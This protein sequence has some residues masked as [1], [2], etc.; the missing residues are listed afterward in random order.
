MSSP[1]F[2]HEGVIALVR[3]E[4]S[5]AASLL[6]DLFRIEVPHFDEARLREAELNQLVPVEYS[7]DAVVLFDVIYDK[8]KPVF[9]TIFEVQLERK[10]RKLY[11]WP[12]YAVAARARYECP[13][14][15][16]AVTPDPAVAQWASQPIDLGDGMTYRVRVIGPDGVPPVT[17]HDRAR[18]EPRLAVLSAV[19]HGHGEVDVAV[20]VARTAIHAVSSLP[21]EQR[22]LYS[23]LIE[24]A[25]SRAARKALVMDPQIEKFF[26]EEHRRSRDQAK[27]EGKAEGEAKALMMI[28][29]HRGMTITDEQQRQIIACSDA[30]TVERW[31]DR[32]LFVASVDELLS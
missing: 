14:V 27:A 18:R 32:A 8:S 7:A 30:A 25:L 10:D 3:D 15:V 22:L 24:K 31:L 23:L 6:R 17:D 4:P 28:L 1:S 21:E 9:G 13:F 5:F 12:L 16:T 11:T 19:A 20:S 2:I 26:T 29:K